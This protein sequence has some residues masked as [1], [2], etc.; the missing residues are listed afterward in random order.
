MKTRKT[1]SAGG[2]V[3]NKKGEV[4]VVD[5]K[6]TSWSLPKGHVEDGEKKLEAAKREIYEESGITDL[7]FVKEFESYQRYR[8]PDSG[9]G[10][11][12][13]EVKTIYMFLFRTRQEKLKPVD[14]HNPQAKWLDRKEVANKLTH[15]KDKKFFQ[16]V[17]RE[18]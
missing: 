3:L 7:E 16:S 9:K 13:S 17:I 5:Q 15:P 14:N 6:G 10:E 18:I 2:V 11:D 4:L 12:R 8:I 1:Q